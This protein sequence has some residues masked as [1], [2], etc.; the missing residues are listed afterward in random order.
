[1]KNHTTN[2]Q[3]T[4]IEVAEDSTVNTAEMPP[5]KGDKKSAAN[6]QFELL[7]ENPYQYTSD[8]VFF[9]VYAIRKELL[10]TD[11]ETERANFFSKGQ[12]YFQASP[13]TKRYG[14]GIHSDETVK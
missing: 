2:Y 3:N 1:M 10:P 9:Q 14:W 13:L 4:F 7:Y 12:P 8:D 6:H 11:L 5:V